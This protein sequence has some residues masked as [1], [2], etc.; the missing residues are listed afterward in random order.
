MCGNLNSWILKKNLWN[1]FL[2]HISCDCWIN[3]RLRFTYSFPLLTMSWPQRLSCCSS[4]IIVVPVPESYTKNHEAT[5]ISLISVY[6]IGLIWILSPFYICPFLL[7][8]EIWLL[9][10]LI[11][12][13]NPS[14]HR[15]THYPAGLLFHLESFLVQAQPLLGCFPNSLQPWWVCFVFVFVFTKLEKNK[16]GRKQLHLIKWAYKNY[17]LSG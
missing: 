10:M 1:R 16:D 8:W 6:T 3:P 4:V 2:G 13:I 7:L 9:N 12:W 5:L 14:N 15:Q 17:P 11:Y